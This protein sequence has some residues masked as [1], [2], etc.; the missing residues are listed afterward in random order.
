[1]TNLTPH[2]NEDAS[3]NIIEKKLVI[4]GQ[5][6]LTAFEQRQLRALAKWDY[7]LS[8]SKY[9]LYLHHRQLFVH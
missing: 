7:L 1:M 2:A 4:V 9:F 3:I 6:E 8:Y 5:P